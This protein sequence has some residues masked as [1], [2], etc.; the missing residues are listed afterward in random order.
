MS[1]WI[2]ICSVDELVPNAGICALV[3][4]K[5]IAIFYIPK[6]D[7]L[8]A[9]DNFDPFSNT[10]V[11]SRGMIGDLNGEPMVASPMY[12]HHFSLITGKCFEESSV[13]NDIYEI[14]VFNDYVKINISKA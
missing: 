2:D 4:H 12:K 3:N 9:I 11:L 10:N 13:V 14:R 7:Q 5:Q 1:H 6:M 8:F